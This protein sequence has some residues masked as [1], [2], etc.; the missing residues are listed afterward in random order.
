MGASLSTREQGIEC[1]CGVHGVSTNPGP[2]LQRQRM[3]GADA[4]G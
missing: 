3:G 4:E 2:W 1:D